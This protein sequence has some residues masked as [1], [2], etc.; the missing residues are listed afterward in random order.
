MSTG[1][2]ATPLSFVYLCLIPCR[3]GVSNYTVED[4]KEL[5]MHASIPPTVNQVSTR[6]PVAHLW[7]N[8]T[9]NLR[10]C[11]NQFEVNPFLYRRNTIKYFADAGVVVQ[12]YRALGQGKNMQ[13]PVV[14]DVANETKRTPAQVLGRW[15]V[16]KGIVYIP[17]SEKTDRCVIVKYL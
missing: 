5:M 9:H 13:H 12:A 11:V 8:H 7:L 3:I 1:R 14:I 2:K 4:H 6:S 10:Y 15:C 17:K 16:Q